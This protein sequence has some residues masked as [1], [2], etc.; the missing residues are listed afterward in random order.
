[1]YRV[2]LSDLE[3][4]V[5]LDEL[6]DLDEVTLRGALK[7]YAAGGRSFFPTVPEILKAAGDLNA[8]RESQPL[9]LEAWGQFCKKIGRV[10]LDILARHPEQEARRVGI[11]PEDSRIAQML[12]GWHHLALMKPKQLDFKAKDFLAFRAECVERQ[13]TEDQLVALEPARPLR[14]PLLAEGGER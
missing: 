14:V 7:R 10:N 8:A 3:M 5:Y 2:E 1:M 9:A 4:D 6:A 12:G 13:H 11:T